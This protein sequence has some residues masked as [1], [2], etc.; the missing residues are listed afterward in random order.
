MEAFEGKD[1]KV[2]DLFKNQWA[3]V[4]AGDA[5]SFNA[6]T[7]GWGSLGTLWTRPGK[8]G[9][10]VTVYIHPARY[11]N[12]FLLAN[13]LFTV[14][15]FPAGC[16]KALGYMGSH[17]GRHEEKTA[18]AGLT[19][20]PMGGSVAFE[21]ATLA[22]LCKKVYQHP[23]SKEG[24]A[25]DVQEYYK[26]NPRPYPVDEKGDWHPHWVFVGDILDVVDKR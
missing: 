23:F 22:F 11:T 6:C 20:I 7:V 3:L 13:D 2:F 4:S 12:E 19:P 1:Y 26:A 16:R 25:Q 8:S 15:F 10:V 17:S 21:E 9:S 14:S 5:R 24:I 18:A